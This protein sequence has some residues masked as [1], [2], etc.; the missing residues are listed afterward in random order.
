M[1]N[2]TVL[3]TR[4][5]G[6]QGVAVCRHLQQNGI[7]IH[8]LVRDASHE[9]AIDLKQFGATLFEGLL[10]DRDAVSIAAN[11]GIPHGVYRRHQYNRNSAMCNLLMVFL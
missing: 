9:R 3:V 4:A 6:S 1:S 10:S 2:F 8:A 5:T 7:K 11:S